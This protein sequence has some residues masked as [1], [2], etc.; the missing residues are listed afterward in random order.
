MNWTSDRRAR[1]ALSSV[2]EAGSPKLAQ[3][4]AA[5]S[6]EEVW[7]GLLGRDE[8]A[9]GARAARLDL[10]ALL[11]RSDEEGIR[12]VIPGD[13]EWPDTLSVLDHVELNGMGGGPVGLWLLGPGHLARHAG[14]SVSIVGSRASTSYGDHVALELAADLAA[15]QQAWTV[16]SGGA[17]G[18]DAAA[19]RG[20]LAAQGRTIAVLAGGLD[21]AYP[22][23][24]ARLFELILADNLLV[25]EVPAGHTPTRAGFLAR[26]RLIA[27]LGQGTVIVEGAARSGAHN[28]IAWAAECGR[29]AMAVPGPVTSGMSVTPHRLIR[30]RRAELVSDADDVRAVVE[31]LGLAPELPLGGAER[32]LDLLSPSA[33]TVRE[34]MPGRGSVDV[35]ALS[36][37][38]GL[39]LPGVLASLSELT[40]VG[41]VEAVGA[42]SWRVV[43]P[44]SR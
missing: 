30:D 40:E 36:V 13:D 34:A 4:L 27:A 31:P 3:L 9:W 22:R 8:S 28:T 17:Y 24:N 19:H 29:P 11:G 41:L 7:T 6:P 15:G 32:R 16:V 23:G 43:R 44:A 2:C 42:D 38:S 12:F 14:R 20:A 18:I 33:R 1:A 21:S 25:S 26:N 5:F 37:T 39:P 35:G 10:E